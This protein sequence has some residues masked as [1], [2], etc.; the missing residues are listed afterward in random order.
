MDET[1]HGYNAS[2]G[3]VITSEP[4]R[5]DTLMQNAH[6]AHGSF[7]LHYTDTVLNTSN[8]RLWADWAV[9]GLRPGTIAALPFIGWLSQRHRL[10]LIFGWCEL[11]LQID[12][13]PWQAHR[14]T[15]WYEAS[16]IPVSEFVARP[17]RVRAWCAVL[18]GEDRLRLGISVQNAQHVEVILRGATTLGEEWWISI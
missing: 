12:G 6:R 8:G 16:A 9:T 5:T 18:P 13:E 17:H 15:S 1:F 3:V 10:P 11:E 2:E 4:A 7:Q 14:T